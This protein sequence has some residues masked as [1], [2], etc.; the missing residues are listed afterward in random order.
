MNLPIEI[1]AMPITFPM[2]AE[3][4][5]FAGYMELIRKCQEG[6]RL[7]HLRYESFLKFIAARIGLETSILAARRKCLRDCSQINDPMLT[8]FL[9][10]LKSEADL[11]ETYL[12]SLDSAIRSPLAA[13][14][15]SANDTTKKMSPQ[16]TAFQ[17]TLDSSQSQ[18]ARAKRSLADCRQRVVQCLP[19]DK[20][21][22]ERQLVK[23]QRSYLEVYRRCDDSR[24]Q[25][26]I[27]LPQLYLGY[28]ED[29]T[30]H[31]RKFDTALKEL[32]TLKGKLLTDMARSMSDLLNDRIRAFEVEKESAM[33]V[34]KVFDAKLSVDGLSARTDLWAVAIDHFRSE[35]RGDLNFDKGD[36]ILVVAQHA[37]E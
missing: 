19:K 24:K 34:E 10:D 30:E 4:D 26:E 17:R 29:N 11:E 36:H 28:E 22:M 1:E 27:Q 3:E 21:Q 31:L 20:E 32:R 33:I 14:Q 13:S 15:R 35:D 7:S 18:L 16:L 23:E 8:P 25:F 6:I 37:S 5:P 9:D 12:Q 2:S